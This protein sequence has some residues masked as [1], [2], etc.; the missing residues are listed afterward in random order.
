MDVSTLYP[1]PSSQG[2][3]GIYILDFLDNQGKHVHHTG[4]NIYHRGF[5]GEKRRVA[6]CTGLISG[7][8]YLT[9]CQV[10]EIADGNDE[11]L[12]VISFWCL[13]RSIAVPVFW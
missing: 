12:K 11:R 5:L 4:L 8:Y 7:T 9:T 13:D 10:V 3:D 2:R 1:N 6:N